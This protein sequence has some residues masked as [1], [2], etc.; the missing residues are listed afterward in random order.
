MLRRRAR[1]RD[2]AASDPH[3]SQFRSHVRIWVEVWN[4][5]PPGAA[6]SRVVSATP[7]RRTS[8]PWHYHCLYLRG[9]QAH[10][11]PPSGVKRATCSGATATSDKFG[12]R[13][14][15]SLTSDTSSGYNY[16]RVQYPFFGTEIFCGTKKFFSVQRSWC[17]WHC[18]TIVLSSSRCIGFQMQCCAIWFKSSLVTRVSS[19][20]SFEACK[21][22]YL[23]L[24]YSGQFY[25]GSWQ[26]YLQWE[27]Q[28]DAG[29]SNEK[30]QHVTPLDR[31]K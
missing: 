5:W 8:P 18:V 30:V 3:L 31:P 21:P 9:I 4:V 19:C 24:P 14:P 1:G 23:G 10:V 15:E 16:S 26:L 11:D 12:H 13:Q 28:R 29:I 2:Q 6:L 17:A 22:V 25:L 20:R 27:V 7:S